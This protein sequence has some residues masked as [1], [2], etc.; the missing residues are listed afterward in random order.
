MNL[1]DFKSQHNDYN[2]FVVEDKKDE[3][4]KLKSDLSRKFHKKL[5]LTILDGK[6]LSNRNQ[7]LYNIGVAFK[8]PDY[9][10]KNWDAFNDCITDLDWISAE[11]YLLLINN[12]DK[13]ESQGENFSIFFNILEDA[14]KVWK[15][16]NDFFPIAIPPTP[17]NIILNT[18]LKKG[19]AI[20]Q[21]ISTILPNAKIIKII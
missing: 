3:L 13:I 19:D 14:A 8:F 9:Y 16:G 10:G 15:K 18:S 2:F 5:Y 11:Y 17:F 20:V 1:Y 21:K 12:A 7:I 6:K 4:K